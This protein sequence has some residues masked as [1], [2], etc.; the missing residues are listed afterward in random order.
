MILHWLDSIVFLCTHLLKFHLCEHQSATRLGLKLSMMMYCMVIGSIIA[1]F[2]LMGG[3][4]SI[5]NTV[6]VIT[7]RTFFNGCPRS[8]H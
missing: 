5:F 1:W 6:V 3:V 2:A 4:F 8:E 7:N